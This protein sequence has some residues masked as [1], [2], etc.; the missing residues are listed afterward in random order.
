MVFLLKLIPIQ[1]TVKSSVSFEIPDR[2]LVGYRMD[3]SG[4]L[5]Y[6]PAIHA[7]ENFDIGIRPEKLDN[8]F[9]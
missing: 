3:W 4:Y 5:G 1:K 7:L 8:I 9:A 6:L 2:F